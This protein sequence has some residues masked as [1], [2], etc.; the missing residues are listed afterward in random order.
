M[1][2]VLPLFLAPM[3]RTLCRHGELLIW[4]EWRREMGTHLNGVG[5]FRLRTLRGL[6]TLTPTVDEAY[7][8]RPRF[9]M[10]SA[11][12]TYSPLGLGEAPALTAYAGE[13]EL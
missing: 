10:L 2:D 6:L 1:N 11:R 13:E 7:E 8:Y 3:T 9:V 4:S 12:S 5:S